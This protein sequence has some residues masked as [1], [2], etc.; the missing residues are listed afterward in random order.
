MFLREAFGAEK[1]TGRATVARLGANAL[2][3]A[4]SDM[5]NACIICALIL[6]GVLG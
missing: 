5:H 3:Q 1:V 6:H 2:K 4:R